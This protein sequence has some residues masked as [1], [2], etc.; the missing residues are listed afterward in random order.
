MSRNVGPREVSSS[1]LVYVGEVGLIL[2]QPTFQEIP[3]MKTNY[4][5]TR[6]R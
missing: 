5:R 4:K 3:A 2:P 6:K 1:D